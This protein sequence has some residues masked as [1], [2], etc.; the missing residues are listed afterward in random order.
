MLIA[1]RHNLFHTAHNSSA[2]PVS[3][4]AVCFVTR[5]RAMVIPDMERA[6]PYCHPAK[7][8]LYREVLK[9]HFASPPV[10]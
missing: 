7:Q 9:L 5:K 10:H 8:P 2:P 4:T 3:S 1:G 6:N